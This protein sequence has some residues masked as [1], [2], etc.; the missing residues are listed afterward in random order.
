[1]GTLDTNTLFRTALTCCLFLTFLVVPL[2]YGQVDSDGDS[3]PNNLELDGFRFNIG[4]GSIEACDP[5]TDDPCYVTDPLSWSSD[6]DPYSDFQEASGV[7]MD[8]SVQ[9]PYNNPLVAAYPVIEVFLNQYSFT[10]NATITDES[11]QTLSSGESFTSSVETTAS[12]SVTVG[13]SASVT[14]GFGVSAEATASYS[15]TNS[16]SSEVTS[17]KELSW[18][19][20]TSTNLNEAGTLSLSL[21]ARNSGGAT[22]LD[23][24]PTFNIYIGHDLVATVR[25]D[26]PFRQSL[27]PGEE[28]APLVPIVNGEP[29]AVNLTFDRLQA[30]QTG[31]PV[32]IE[33]VDIEANIQRWRPEDSNWECGTGETCSWTSFQNQILPRTLRLLVDFGYSGDPN[34]DV[35]FQFRGNPFEY[36]VYTG[37]PS[38][39]PEFTLREILEIVDYDMTQSG[40]QVNI[41]GRPYPSTW[42]LAEQPDGGGFTPIEQAWFDAGQPQSLLDV[43][44]PRQAT[45]FMTSSDPA[46]PGAAIRS[47]AFTKDLLNIRAVAAPRAGL[48]I[49]EATAHLYLNGEL[50]AVP[51]NLSP[52]GSYWTTEGGEFLVEDAIGVASS[53]VEFVDIAGNVQRSE[54]TLPLPISQATSCADVD[55]ADITQVDGADGRAIIFPDGDL[56]TPVEVYCVPGQATTR[57]WVPQDVATTND[58]RDIVIL[59][60]K[61]AVAVGS[62]IILKTTDRGRTWNEVSGPYPSGSWY[63]VDYN[64]DTNTLVAAGRIS[65]QTARNIRSTDG[66]E[67][68]TTISGSFHVLF[69]LDYAGD[70]VWFLGGGS[71]FISTPQVMRSTDDGISWTRLTSISVTGVSDLAFKDAQTGFVVNSDNSTGALLKTTDGGNTWSTVLSKSEN[72]F[73]SID[74]AGDNTWVLAQGDYWESSLSRMYRSTED[75]QAGTWTETS[76]DGTIRRPGETLFISPLVGFVEEWG[77]ND[78]TLEGLFM[79]T[80]GGQ[81]WTEEVPVSSDY[82]VTPVA[83]FDRNRI[84]AVG[85]KT[86][87]AMTT[88]GG[89]G[90]PTIIV[91]TDPEV[92]GPTA[93]GFDLDQ[94][95][96]N[97]FSSSTTFEYS[98]DVPGSVS[99]IVYDL[100]G[101]EV[102]KLVDG[103]QPS[104]THSVSFTADGI[105]SGVYLVRLQVGERSVTKR[106]MHVE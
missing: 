34:A 21:F 33:V 55:P 64:P 78:Q 60:E 77:N 3:I 91:G 10:S 83:V 39:N 51:L 15:E 47:T 97:P 50:Q 59:D 31:A 27:A 38:T 71:G 11:G 62:S 36:R 54:G 26:F 93:A 88:S 82:A 66:G 68:W 65:E 49:V 105:S 52:F 72:G 104:G 56:N 76:L 42:A 4:I 74:Y 20:A 6:G 102:A 94:N 1:M 5:E 13:T 23:V 79:T 89:N 46:D 73:T 58:I 69:N 37:S 28:S 29:L 45:L 99:L 67:T 75:G 87:V 101:R 25:P 70:G 106:I 81:T 95:Y 86:G 44:M 90:M 96:P 48:P 40:G 85:G 8:A 92:V 63:A 2:A 35:P 12:V 43:V 16:Y 61:T 22:A 17:G 14:D 84:L 100:L 18:E 9:V 19:T 41:E 57:Y 103:S 32:V 7:N 24:I 98:L 80:D 30:L 53:Y